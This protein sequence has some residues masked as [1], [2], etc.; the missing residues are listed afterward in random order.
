MPNLLNPEKNWE[1][2]ADAVSVSRDEIEQRIGPFQESA[3]MLSGGLANANV[4]IGKEK[5]LRVYRR[6]PGVAGKERTLLEKPW[7]TFEVPKVL[8]SGRDFLLL[9]YIPHR[10]LED[11]P[12]HG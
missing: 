6:D 3:E 9:S 2:N 12:E 1:R 4:L 8:A 7:R 10:P 5:V 11:T